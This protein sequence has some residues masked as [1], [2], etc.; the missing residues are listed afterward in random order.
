MFPAFQSSHEFRWLHSSKAFGDDVEVRWSL[1]SASLLVW[2]SNNSS[3]LQTFPPLVSFS[4]NLLQ[5]QRGWLKR[6]FFGLGGVSLGDPLFPRGH[7]NGASA[8]PSGAGL[9]PG[10][11]RATQLFPPRLGGKMALLAAGRDETSLGGR[12]PLCLHLTNSGFRK[13]CGRSS[14]IL[15]S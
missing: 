4:P 15:E 10:R 14:R 9:L 1:A 7:L 13:R 5:E 12:G 8:H 11:E 3:T 6:Q 2:P